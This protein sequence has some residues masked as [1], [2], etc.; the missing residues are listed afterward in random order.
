MT[1]FREIIITDNSGNAA[2]VTLNGQLKV[3]AAIESID[4]V[5]VT[6]SGEDKLRIQDLEIYS[7]LENMLKE[8]KKMN[9]YL[10]EITSTEI[11]NTDL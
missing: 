3:D 6:E 2:D 5:T 8:L 10:S 11:K 7:L 9:L 1:V 4:N